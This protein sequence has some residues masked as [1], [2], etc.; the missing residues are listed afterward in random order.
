MTVKKTTD[1]CICKIQSCSENM[2]PNVQ[3]WHKARYSQVEI[4]VR[5]LIFEKYLTVN[6]SQLPI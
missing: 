2:K 1:I 4:L 3:N 6:L 5:L